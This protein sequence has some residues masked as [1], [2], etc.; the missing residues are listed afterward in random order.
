MVAHRRRSRLF[1]I[2]AGALVVLLALAVAR[3]SSG[4]GTNGTGAGGG[5][6]TT[7]IAAGAGI[8]KPPPAIAAA[9]R[10]RA[11]ADAKNLLSRVLLPIGAV[12]LSQEPS[13]DG[14]ALSRP[15]TRPA[16]VP[17]LV[18]E[19]AWWRVPGSAASA[20]NYV[21]AH[22]PRG[23]KLTL[24]G[25]QG[26]IDGPPVSRFVGF[27]WPPVDKLLIGRQV[28][29]DAV[30]LA[31]GGAGVRVDAQ[32]EWIVP[33][34]ASE[35]IPHGVH[36]IDVTR[37][38]PGQSPSLSIKVIAAGQI[39]ALVA[40]VDALEIVQPGAYSC[41]N[42]QPGA[43][44]VTFTFRARDGGTVLATASQSAS[45]REPTTSCDP[46]S[47]SIRGRSQ[48]PLLGGAAVVHR[49]GRLLGV[50]LQTPPA[51]VAQPAGVARSVH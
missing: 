46:M 39:R 4:A 16:G 6:G 7:G 30:D 43:L 49:A 2:V 29:V 44:V 48:T 14:G 20:L 31:G 9:R 41:P 8:S 18:D 3:V 10:R 13:G 11:R 42:R 12:E 24:S 51:G 37:G 47:F 19:H 23:G 36:E 25:S 45:A 26:P 15:I 35:R 32:V 34:P 28:L 5:A 22:P 40:M 27:S 38:A 1:A 33:R 50:R 21:G 17:E